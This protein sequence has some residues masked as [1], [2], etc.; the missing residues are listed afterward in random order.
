MVQEGSLGMM[1][2]ALGIL[3]WGAFSVVAFPGGA[4]APFFGAIPSFQF[5]CGSVLDA[6]TSGQSQ[7]KCSRL[8][9]W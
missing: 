8:L 7:I 4:Q 9:Q 1:S 5:K 3:Y 2:Y 6:F